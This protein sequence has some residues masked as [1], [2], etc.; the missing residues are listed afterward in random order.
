MRR[1]SHAKHLWRAGV[2]ESPPMTVRVFFAVFCSVISAVHAADTAQ[3]ADVFLGDSLADGGG[4]F[5]GAGE[6]LPPNFRRSG[7]SVKLIAGDPV[8][9]VRLP[10]PLAQ[11]AP[12]NFT[13]T[14]AYSGLASEAQ[15][16][17]SQGEHAP[18]GALCL[19]GKSGTSLFLAIVPAPG[20][21]DMSP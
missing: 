6:A 11:L 20:L 5:N 1:P 12:C 15:E 7:E 3:A 18:I 10:K 8:R 17:C 13:H 9:P 21:R 4:R 14:S 2:F 19:T 16:G